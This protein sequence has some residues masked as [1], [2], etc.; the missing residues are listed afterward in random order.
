[1]ELNLMM[2]LKCFPPRN[3]HNSMLSSTAPPRT[4]QGSYWPQ[5]G[6]APPLSQFPFVPP[7]NWLLPLL[8]MR[9]LRLRELIYGLPHRPPRGQEFK[10]AFQPGLCG[11]GAYQGAWQVFLVTPE[12]WVPRGQSVSPGGWVWSGTQKRGTTRPWSPAAVQEEV[13]GPP[14]LWLGRGCLD[15]DFEDKERSGLNF[16]KQR[17]PNKKNV[18]S[19]LWRWAGRK[20][21]VTA[22]SLVF[23]LKYVVLISCP[24]PQ[25]H[26]GVGSEGFDWYHFKFTAEL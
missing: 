7:T 20:R 12:P 15:K 10:L 23:I 2:K 11:P 3:F 18:Q 17:F 1:M 8:Q 13:C 25:P 6:W 24:P 16:P 9:R 5:R 14:F 19:K 22:G 4:S 21:E 26:P